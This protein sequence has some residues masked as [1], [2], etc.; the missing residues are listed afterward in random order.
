M[1]R[2]KCPWCGAFGQQLPTGGELQEPQSCRRR[3]RVS[4]ASP[5]TVRVIEGRHITESEW[6]LHCASSTNA[7][8]S[9]PSLH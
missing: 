6:T 2:K 5:V 7:S 1:Q 9:V 8:E 4:M 3:G